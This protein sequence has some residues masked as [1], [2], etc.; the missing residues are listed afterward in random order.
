MDMYG[1]TPYRS[2]FLNY[3]KRDVE[4]TIALVSVNILK[5]PFL[6]TEEIL[7]GG[8]E[9]SGLNGVKTEERDNNFALT[10]RSYP[11]ASLPRIPNVNAITSKATVSVSPSMIMK[12]PNPLP[13]SPIASQAQAAHVP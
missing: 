10:K 8:R 13:V 9:R 6:G 3:F 1:L 7:A 2:L 12:L 5:R 11:P 4:V